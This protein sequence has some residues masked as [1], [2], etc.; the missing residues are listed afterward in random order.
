MKKALNTENLLTDCFY[1]IGSFYVVQYLSLPLEGDWE[2]D[3]LEVQLT[4]P[5]STEIFFQSDSPLPPHSLCVC[6][7][8]RACIHAK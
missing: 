7:R 6:V 5:P 8:A 2:N 1:N 3:C 4:V